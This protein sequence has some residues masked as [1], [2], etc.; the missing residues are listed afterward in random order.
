MNFTQFLLILKARFW[1]ILITFSAIVFTTLIVSLLLPK[2]YEATTSLVLNYKG[3]DPVT[4]TVLPAQLMPGYMATQNDIIT[5]KNVAI[6]VVEQLKFADSPAAQAQFN[7]AT[8]G[9]GEI[10]EWFAERLLRELTVKPSKES[11]VIEVSFEGSD[12]DFAAAVANSFANAYIQTSLQLKVEPAQK[13]AA[14]LDEQTKALRDNLETAQNKMSKYQQEK[15]ITGG[16]GSLDV[17]TARLNDLSSQLVMVQSQA[18]EAESRSRNAQSKGV[19]SPDIASSSVVQNMKVDISR[20]ESKLSELSERVGKSHPQ[21]QSAKAELDKLKK[22]LQEEVSNMSTSVGGT[23]RIY[24]QREAEIRAALAA[25]KERVL[26]LNLSRDELSVLQRDVENAQ[27][28]MDAASQRFTQATIEGNANQTDVAILNA[29]TAPQSSASPKVVLNVLLS[30]F[31]GTMLGVGLALLAEMLDRR[32]R[33]R[34]DLSDLLEVPVFAI[35]DGKAAST[36]I[37][38][39]SKSSQHLLKA[40]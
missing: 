20:A 29:A 32:V 12:P 14:F 4:G 18:F 23:A 8:K 25:Q 1:I 24:Q 22:S 17:E 31:L 27:K 30:I 11:S 26:K 38:K 3:M 13:A 5:S 15:G 10:R 40:A 34:D 2:T 35:I 9:K 7:Q 19:T 33:S 6:K 16:M 36:K 37:K 39:L 28:A 21:Y